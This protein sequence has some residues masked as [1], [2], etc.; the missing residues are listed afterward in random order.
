MA[1]A[2]LHD[3]DDPPCLSTRTYGTGFTHIH[4]AP[5]T[6]AAGSARWAASHRLGKEVKMSESIKDTQ[7]QAMNA[8]SRRLE[9]AREGTV[10]WNRGGPI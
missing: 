1:L 3:G 7:T 9:E 5:M 6:R 4:K 2:R 10:A 8:E